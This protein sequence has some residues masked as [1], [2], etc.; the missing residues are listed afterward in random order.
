MAYK[1]CSLI[2]ECRSIELSSESRTGTPPV[3]LNEAVA[4]RCV[5]VLENWDDSYPITVESTKIWM[6][7]RR[8]G[9][10]K[11]RDQDFTRKEEK[12]REEK[13]RILFSDSILQYV[14]RTVVRLF[15]KI[16][17]HIRLVQLT[18]GHFTF[19]LFFVMTDR[20]YWRLKMIIGELYRTSM[21]PNFEK[22]TYN[23]T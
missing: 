13:T 19:Y 9:E 11:G 18:D 3:S 4:L 16:G 20:S 23:C 21:T 12:R 22:H 15:L 10:R 6:Q 17:C 2:C 8:G 5:F 14:L 1:L 7:N